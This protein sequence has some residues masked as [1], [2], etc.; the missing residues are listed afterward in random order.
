MRHYENAEEFWNQR[1]LL[2]FARY[3]RRDGPLDARWCASYVHRYYEPL[4]AMRSESH[5][6]H[7]ARGFVQLAH[8]YCQVEERARTVHLENRELLGRI[9]DL[10][11]RL[12]SIYPAPDNS[13]VLGG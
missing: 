12:N 11:A 5:V 6:T 10:E 3:L 9:V 7:M 2:S 4:P 13:P 1:G 8:L